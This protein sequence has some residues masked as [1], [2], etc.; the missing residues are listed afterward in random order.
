MNVIGARPDGWWRDRTGGDG[1]AHRRARRARRETGEPVTVVFDGAPA[2]CRRRRVDVRFASRR[3]RD[4]ADDD[5]AALAA[6]DADPAPPAR[7]DLRRR[8][9]RP[10]PRRPAPSASAPARSAAGS[11]LELEREEPGERRAKQRPVSAWVYLL[12]CADGSL[13][14]GWT[15]DLDRRLAAPR[16]GHARA[17]TRAAAGRSSSRSRCRCPT[18]PRRGARRRASS[19]A[20]GRE[21][22]AGRGG[23]AVVAAACRCGVAVLTPRA[24]RHDGELGH[25]RPVDAAA[26]RSAAR[27]ARSPRPRR[28]T[29]PSSSD[30]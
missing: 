14:S 28:G 27:A 2:R 22:R 13:Y 15:V 20:A 4:A 3:G 24:L 19:A 1:A 7:R 26:P 21:A 17:P 16:R 11:T 9:R 30:R 5:I 10:G 6:A 12:R 25:E 8:A 23:S 29:R 18:A